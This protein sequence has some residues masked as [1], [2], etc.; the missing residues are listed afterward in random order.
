MPIDQRSLSESVSTVFREL[1]ASAETLNAVSDALGKA[2]AEIDE[3]LKNLN[4]GIEA[5]EEIYAGADDDYFWGRLIGYAKTNGRWGISLQTYEGN[6]PEDRD[7]ETWLFNDAPRSL[8]LEAIEKIPALL[9]KLNAEAKQTTIELQARLK[10]VFTV[11]ETLK[12]LAPR[13]CAPGGPSK[14][15]AKVPKVVIVDSNPK[16]EER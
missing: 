2:I 15:Q 13:S 8:R 7:V 12:L 14:S 11:A 5:W 6:D 16:G 4:L 3:S 9:T 1:S 10:N